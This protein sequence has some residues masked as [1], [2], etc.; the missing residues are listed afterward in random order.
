MLNLAVP[1]PVGKTT[2][3][4]KFR[5]AILIPVEILLT[6]MHVIGTLIISAYIY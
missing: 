4:H 6:H 2:A 3:I 5:A 1:N